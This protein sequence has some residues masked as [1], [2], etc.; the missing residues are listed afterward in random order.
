MYANLLILTNSRSR[1]QITDYSM[2]KIYICILKHSVM[3]QVFFNFP[4]KLCN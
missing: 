2:P 3:F 4:F 1:M